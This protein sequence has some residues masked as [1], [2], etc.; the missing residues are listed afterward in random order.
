MDIVRTP[1]I[2]GSFECEAEDR[3]REISARIEL[4][5]PR[6]AEI[7]RLVAR[8]LSNK[9]I[10]RVLEISHHTVSTHIRQIFCKLG[11]NRRVQLA[12]CLAGDKGS[13][14]GGTKLPPARRY[15]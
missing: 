12:I 1:M 6:E 2:A 11:M 13:A 9:E 14:S 3:S 7:V 4:L 5:T 8:G 10:A 15:R